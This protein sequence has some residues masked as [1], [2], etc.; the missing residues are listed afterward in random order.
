MQFQHKEAGLQLISQATK[1]GRASG[2]KRE[3]REDVQQ[4]KLKRVGVVIETLEERGK[5]DE[6]GPST[7]PTL[8]EMKLV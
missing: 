6:A 3:Y 4:G 2:G 7:V 1:A 8:I 5:W